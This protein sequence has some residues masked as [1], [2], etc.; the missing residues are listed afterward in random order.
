[1]LFQNWYTSSG[2]PANNNIY[3]TN[4]D[5]L[6]TYVNYWLEIT[7]IK[8]LREC[9]NSSFYS[10]SFI[11]NFELVF[12]LCIFCECVIVLFEGHILTFSWYLI[13][14]ME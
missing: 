13:F 5:R 9:N 14:S 7:E 2:L 8:Q 10:Y 12:F 1:M 4:T 6:C 11:K 3:D